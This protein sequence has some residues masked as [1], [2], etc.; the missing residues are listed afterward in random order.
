VKIAL[1]VSMLVSVGGV[2]STNHVATQV[3]AKAQ[4]EVRM[5]MTINSE[6]KDH[7]KNA[8]STCQTPNSVERH[9][10]KQTKVKHHR[11][12]AKKNG[13]LRAAS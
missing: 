3:T 9:R 4:E 6:T 8:S 11:G 1:L 5:T 10:E 7:R 2:S 13:W 12:I